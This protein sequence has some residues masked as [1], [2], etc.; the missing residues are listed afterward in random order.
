ME[1]LSRREVVAAF[2]GLGAH[3][4]SA[5]SQNA[6]GHVVSVAG[7]AAGPLRRVHLPRPCAPRMPLAPC[8]VCPLAGPRTWHLQPVCP[9]ALL[10][11]QTDL[12]DVAFAGCL[13]GS[14]AGG[15]REGPRT[16]PRGRRRAG[17][18]NQGGPGLLPGTPGLA[19]HT[20]L[21]LLTGWPMGA[22]SGRESGGNGNT[23]VQLG[24]AARLPRYGLL[25]MPHRPGFCSLQPW[26]VDTC[27][28][29]ALL[30]LKKA[31]SGGLRCEYQPAPGWGRLRRCGA[32]GA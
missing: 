23:R 30:C 27:D 6:K 12:C 14:P 21:L 17:V 1:L 11:L 2:W 16:G 4:G 25:S 3:W 22:R 26:H 32:A 28:L 31:K 13:P 7:A 19:D 10:S 24:R 18:P 29:V 5:R 8:K 9:A 15:A 20:L